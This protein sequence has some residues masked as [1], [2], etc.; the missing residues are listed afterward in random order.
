VIFVGVV[1]LSMTFLIMVLVNV[2]APYWAI[3]VA[4]IFQG[5]GN[6]LCFSELQV[7]VQTDAAKP[8]VPVA[9]SFSFL[10]RMLSQTLTAAVYG[11]LMNH[12]LR[13]GVAASAGKITIKMM[14]NL[15]NAA[16]NK[17]LPQ[18]LLPQMRGIMFT[19]LHHIMGLGLALMACAL[20][21][22]LWALRR[23]K[24]LRQSAE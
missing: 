13:V 11:L 3:L 19:G 1:T 23:E 22:N 16:S 9:T 24:A 8:D 17:S 18:A 4:G 6:G 7:K 5:Y 15:S 2:H 20:V 21:V 10:I 12:A 14:N